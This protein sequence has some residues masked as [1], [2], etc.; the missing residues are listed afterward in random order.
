MATRNIF[1]C[2]GSNG[3]FIA[4]GY[5]FILII[6]LGSLFPNFQKQ[7]LGTKNSKCFRLQTAPNVGVL[8]VFF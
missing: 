5:T 6:F 8:S 2:I 1:V 4:L 3:I 7:I